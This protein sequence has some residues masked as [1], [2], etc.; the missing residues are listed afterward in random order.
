MTTETVALVVAG[1]V[2]VLLQARAWWKARIRNHETIAEQTTV[3]CARCG[4]TRPQD[5][6]DCPVC[7]VPRGHVHGFRS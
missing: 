3:R 2:V 4:G 6:I 7:D 1:T 5:V